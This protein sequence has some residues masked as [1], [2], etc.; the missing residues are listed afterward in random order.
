MI[1]MMSLRP[2]GVFASR[3]IGTLLSRL[4]KRKGASD[5]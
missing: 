3:E 5:V 2:G 4:K 1:V